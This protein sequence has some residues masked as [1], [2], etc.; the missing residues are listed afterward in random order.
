MTVA[1]L[2]LVLQFSQRT[3][4][5]ASSSFLRNH[6]NIL[7]YDTTALPL[8]ARMASDAMYNNDPARARQCIQQLLLLQTCQSIGP[9]PG[10]DIFFHGYGDVAN[11]GLPR[12]RGGSRRNTT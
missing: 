3:S 9:G 1:A 4:F 7:L 2:Q 6:A 5:A 10:I 11:R 8:L 12:R